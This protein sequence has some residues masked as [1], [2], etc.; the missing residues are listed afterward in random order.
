MWG[1]IISR[2]W[3]FTG[4][5][6]KAT[7]DPRSRLGPNH[8]ERSQTLVAAIV[9]RLQRPIVTMVNFRLKRA[10]AMTHAATVDRL[11]DGDA[12][13][14]ARTSAKVRQIMVAVILMS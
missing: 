8:A 14:R 6:S 13:P 12:W 11:M 5:G 1:K 3:M 2:E 4:I 10:K 7:L 9:R